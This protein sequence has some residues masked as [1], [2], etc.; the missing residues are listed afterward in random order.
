MPRQE[1]LREYA[2]IGVQ[3]RVDRYCDQ[4]TREMHL[5]ALRWQLSNCTGPLV[6]ELPIH[7]EVGLL[8]QI[9]TVNGSTHMEVALRGDDVECDPAESGNGMII[10]RF[11]RGASNIYRPQLDSGQVLHAFKDHTLILP[12]G[13]RVRAYICAGHPLGV[14]YKGR[15]LRCISQLYIGIP[16]DEDY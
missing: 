10:K 1:A 6:H 8:S 3:D 14:F 15:A 11:F 2:H 9:V 16:A 13:T 12:V 5:S 7:T 4:I